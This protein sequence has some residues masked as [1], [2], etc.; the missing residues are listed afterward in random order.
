MG[1]CAHEVRQDGQYGE[2]GLE[3]SHAETGVVMYLLAQTTEGLW[4]TAYKHADNQ[5]TSG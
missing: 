3:P 1:S 4:Q 2:Q 5:K